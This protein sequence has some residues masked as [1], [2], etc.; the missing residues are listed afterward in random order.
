MMHMQ[1]LNPNFPNKRPFFRISISKRRHNLNLNLNNHNKKGLINK[2]YQNSYRD[3]CLSCSADTKY[4]FHKETNIL[5]LLY[6]EL[7]DV[8]ENVLQ[9]L[10][11]L[12]LKNG[13]NFIRGLNGSYAL[14][15]IDLNRDTN[16]VVTDRINSRKIFQYVDSDCFIFSNSIYF[17]NDF[18]LSADP[19]AI[20][21]YLSNGAVFNSRTLFKEIKV[22][23]RASITEISSNHIKQKTY[24]EYGFNNEYKNISEKELTNELHR[25]L[26]KSVEKRIKPNDEIYISLSGGYDSA[27]ILGIIRYSLKLDDVKT[28]SYTHGN[29]SC[30]SDAYVSKSMAEECG[31]RFNILPIYNNNLISFLEKN[32]YWGQGTANI[33]DE[34]NAINTIS[35][36]LGDSPDNN[37][38]FGDEC[39]GWVAEPIT[40]KREACRALRI[41]D[42]DNL[43]LLD[44][45]LPSHL[46]SN[47]KFHRF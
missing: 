25:L 30:K 39:F 22:L 31:Y 18:S 15:I 10:H 1:R 34:I 4:F 47:L 37:L 35:D 26:I 17:F 32:A 41:Y 11:S 45:F 38:F 14:F 6:G 46:F 5:I 2:K 42:F 33:C 8:N 13:I 36:E 29:I 20:A 43:R 21:W 19:K 27:A 16:Y 40:S 44:K 28:F 23:K 3:I 12:Y 7:Y 9:C 24:W